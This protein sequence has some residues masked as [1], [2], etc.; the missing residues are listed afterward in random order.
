LKKLNMKNVE[1]RVDWRNVSPEHINHFRE[2]AEN[3]FAPVYK[4]LAKQVID[5]YGVTGGICIDI[6][7]G[8]GGFGSEIAKI[9]GLKVYALDIKE[10]MIE[11]MKEKIEKEKLTARV[12]PKLGDVHNL[13]FDDNF[14][15]LVV[16][17]GSFHFWRDKRRAFLEIHRVLKIGGVGFI[18][19][20]FGRDKEVRKKAMRLHEET[21]RDVHEGRDFYEN[22]KIKYME[23]KEILK[24]AQ[25]FNIIFDESG[26]WVE[27]KKT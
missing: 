3:I 6:G 21:Y 23:L 14:A 26:L 11:I 22:L 25:D 16:S 10:E 13:P 20:G 5:D 4:V 24:G 27:I 18:G 8:T 2:T 1:D 17:R 19:G 7:S 12:I 15:D 9:S